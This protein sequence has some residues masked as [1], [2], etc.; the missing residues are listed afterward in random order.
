MV[1]Q[2]TRHN[3]SEDL[4]SLVVC[5]REEKRV[6]A[7]YFGQQVLKS[8]N[9][10]VIKSQRHQVLKSSKSHGLFV[11]LLLWLRGVFHSTV[12]WHCLLAVLALCQPDVTSAM[13]ATSAQGLGSGV[14]VRT[15]S[16]QD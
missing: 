9:L 12:A 7:C 16:I 4:P 3:A 1:L 14:V 2:S 8:S 11:G 15:L 10:K 5:G 6:F 13:D